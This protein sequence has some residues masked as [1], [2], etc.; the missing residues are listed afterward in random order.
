M[1]PSFV[2]TPP[3]NEFADGIALRFPQRAFHQAG[4]NSSGRCWNEAS[5]FSLS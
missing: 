5:Q 4:A 3:S 2:S 1:T